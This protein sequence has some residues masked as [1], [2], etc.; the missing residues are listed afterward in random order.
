MKA[1]MFVVLATMIAACNDVSSNMY[2]CKQ[3]CAPNPVKSYEP[4]RDEKGSRCNCLVPEQTK[5][6]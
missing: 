2:A 4:S 6:D 5:K 3:M 1:M